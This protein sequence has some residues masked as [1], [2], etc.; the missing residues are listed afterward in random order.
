METIFQ[1]NKQMII[2]TIKPKNKWETKFKI[3]NLM[4]N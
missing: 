4:V 2:L 3:I 1:S